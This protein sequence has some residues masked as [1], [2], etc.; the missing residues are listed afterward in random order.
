[1]LVKTWLMEKKR[2]ILTTTPG[3]TLMSA[4][5]HLIENKISCLPVLEENGAL[6][7]IISDKDIFQATYKDSAIIGY[8][9]VYCTF[10]APG[11][12]DR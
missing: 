5:K 6:I 9:I 1:M 8:G 3:T 11:K 12:D 2:E 10:Q 7:G 4:M